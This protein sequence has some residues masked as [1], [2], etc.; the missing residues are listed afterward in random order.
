VALDPLDGYAHMPLAWYYWYT[1]DFA[2]AVPEFERAI[3]LNP[4]DA[5]VLA[6]S[7]VALPWLGK[8]EQAV[9]LLERAM[10]LNPHFPNWYLG[11]ARDVYFYAGQFEKS[12]AAAKQKNSPTSWDVLTQP[13]AY[14][15]LGR[16]E[17]AAAGVAEFLKREPDY[18]AEKWLSDMGTYARDSEL[19][20]FLDSNRKAGLPVCA[21]EAQLAKYP[22]MKRLDQCEAQRASG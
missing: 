5:D 13:L 6:L 12:I 22:D 7:A 3:D 11:M 20:L 10:R 19:N 18:S 15:Q 17:E 21:T 9:E 2:H 16:E 8:P 4:N 14:A 1:S